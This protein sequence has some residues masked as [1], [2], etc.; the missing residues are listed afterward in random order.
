MF[1]CA[2]QIIWP[3]PRNCSPVPNAFIYGI[4]NADIAGGLA[5]FVVD[6]TF[7]GIFEA[8]ASGNFQ[9]AG[10]PVGPVSVLALPSTATNG[11]TS[12]VAMGSL[13]ASSSLTL[14]PIMGNSYAF[15]FGRD[16]LTDPNGFVYDI[17]CAG[18][19]S[20]GGQNN[21]FSP[22]DSAG[23]LFLNGNDIYG[24]FT[25]EPHNYATLDQ[26][27]N[28]LTIGP[29]S[30]GVYNLLLQIQRKVFVPAVGG[31]VRMVDSLTNP[32]DVPI[33]TNVLIFN[34][35]NYPSAPDTLVADPQTNGNT[36]AVVQNSTN[37]LSP[38]LGF[39]FAGKN[40]AVPANAFPSLAAP[41]NYN[42]YLNYQWS[43]ITA[44]P[45]FAGSVTIGPHQTMSFM[46][47]II[48]WNNQDVA[49]AIAQ[50]QA[51]VNLTDP[52]ELVGLSAQEKAQVVNFNVP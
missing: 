30:G 27:G 28:Q 34:R 19:I 49:G 43:Q 3:T 23:V 8:D 42:L 11:Q 20:G 37:S 51:L 31:Y 25:C 5:D 52:N 39:V 47:F 35:F 22:F 50:A 45:E 32:L 21:G 12:G 29:H 2:A 33:A 40:P 17:Y 6:G 46:H 13:T 7:G 10:V 15:D 4:E 24:S 9:I 44:A 16:T 38:I 1:T 36:F 18:G 14:N 26:S 41:Y 48:Q